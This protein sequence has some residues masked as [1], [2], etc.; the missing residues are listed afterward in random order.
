L[1]R[2]E[3]ENKVIL[4]RS[5]YHTVAAVK[6]KGR[7]HFYDPNIGDE[8]YRLSEQNFVDCLFEHL[9]RLLSNPSAEYLPINIEIFSDAAKSPDPYPCK[10]ECISRFLQ[11][12]PNFTRDSM[13]PGY[14][15]IICAARNGDS[16]TAK[17][18]LSYGASPQNSYKGYNC[19]EFAA[20]YNQIETVKLFHQAGESIDKALIQV[21]KF[22]WLDSLRTLLSM[23][24]N[25]HCR[26]VNGHSALDMAS[27]FGNLESMV[28]LLKAGAWS[29]QAFQ[30]APAHDQTAKA[31]VLRILH[32]YAQ[33]RTAA[34]LSVAQ[35]A[36]VSA[37]PG[38]APKP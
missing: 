29:E 34:T 2:L 10:E 23:G 26:D 1:A 37:S 6:R 17:L 9:A 27:A 28:I 25:V 18:L 15:A 35:Q 31:N 36:P 11:K 12:D 16:Q 24:A 20:A 7:Y 5:P 4:I 19:I 33:Y 22:E 38:L 21:A 13:E 8:L 14:T 3:L 30:L 32:Q